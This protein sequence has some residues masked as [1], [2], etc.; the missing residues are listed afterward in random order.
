MQRADSL[1]LVPAAKQFSQHRR[2][3]KGFCIQRN[4]RGCNRTEIMIKVDP[5]RHAFQDTGGS[6]NRCVVEAGFPSSHNKLI[7]VSVNMVF[8]LVRRLKKHLN[9]NAPPSSVKVTMR[10]I[11]QIGCVGNQ[12]F[13]IEK[14]ALLCRTRIKPCSKIQALSGTGKFRVAF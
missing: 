8:Y 3:A 13:W 7:P 9:F 4:N 1:K 11:V 5:Q 6:S 14:T 2:P 10:P 12:D